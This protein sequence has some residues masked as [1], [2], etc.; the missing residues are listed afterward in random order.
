MPSRCSVS[1]R[2]IS[3]AGHHGRSTFAKSHD[4]HRV[5][6][7]APAGDVV[8]RLLHPHQAR[9]CNDPS[10]HADRRAGIDR[11]RL[12]V[13]HHV[14]PGFAAFGR[15]RNLASLPVS[16]RP[17]QRDPV[18]VDRLGR[19][20]CRRRAGDHSQF[21]FADLH[22]FPD[23]RNCPPAGP[24]LSKIVRRCRRDG[25]HLP[26]H[27]RPGVRRPGRAAHCADRHCGGDDL[28]RRR[29]RLQPRVQRARSDGARGGLAAL[30]RG[31]PSAGQHRGGT[32]LDAGAIRQFDAGA[33]RACSI[34]DGV[35]LRDL[36]P[37][38]SDAGVRWA[39]R[40][41]LTCGCR[42]ASRSVCCCSARAF[43]RPP[44]S[45]LAA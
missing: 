43:L 24:R 12:I 16:G 1:S 5:V 37:A 19:T 25:R 29:R 15:C 32:A 42:S 30:R 44:G 36:F 6:A 23:P 28:L 40:P 33:A 41:R 2:Q 4:R 22:V 8:G 7:A 27:R 14:L 31:N 13:V 39:P 26:D 38:D 3:R 10:D 18:D 9:R 11:E 34:L 21:H 35:C 20:F 45:V 17:Q